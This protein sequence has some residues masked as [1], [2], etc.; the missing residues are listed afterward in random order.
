M[1]D[2][3]KKE[4]WRWTESNWKNPDLD[5]KTAQYITVG[6][7][8][9]SVF[10]RSHTRSHGLL[11]ALRGVRVSGDWN[12]VPAGFLDGRAQLL[13]AEC[14]VLGVVANGLERTGYE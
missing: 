14:D 13:R 5:W 11:D 6:I 7:D 12:A 3:N 9:G 2:E 4:F 10:D 1:V 8:V